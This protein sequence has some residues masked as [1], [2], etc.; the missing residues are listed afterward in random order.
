MGHH[1]GY[2]YP[3][4]SLGARRTRGPVRK[5]EEEEEEEG[6]E[7]RPLNQTHRLVEHALCNEALV[8]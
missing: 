6:E 3:L 2:N 7:A 1:E 5:E 8:L 4:Q